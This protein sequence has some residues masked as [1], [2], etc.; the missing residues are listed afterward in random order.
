M[1]AI[2]NSS[3]YNSG[4][5]RSSCQ[6]MGVVKMMSSSLNQA[7]LKSKARSAF[8]CPV[9]Y[10]KMTKQDQDQE[11]QEEEERKL[12][13]LQLHGRPTCKLLKK[14]EL[15]FRDELGNKR[16]IPENLRLSM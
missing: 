4:Y 3:G 12:F 1:K 10:G 8:A 5:W 7:V 6:I 2:Y 9:F 11:R 15:Y 14:P 13:Y 16:N